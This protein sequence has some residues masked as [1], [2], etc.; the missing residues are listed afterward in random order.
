MYSIRRVTHQPWQ[1]VGYAWISALH[2]ISIVATLTTLRRH[3]ASSRHEI[4]AI[5]RNGGQQVGDLA[6]KQQHADRDRRHTVGLLQ[7]GAD[8]CEP[9]RARECRV[10]PAQAEID[11]PA[12]IEVHWK[13]HFDLV[14]A[15]TPGHQAQV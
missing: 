5:A 9:A 12:V 13:N 11:D 7:N 14:P 3:L 15:D 8:A 4:R 2:S 10:W 1:M 6:I